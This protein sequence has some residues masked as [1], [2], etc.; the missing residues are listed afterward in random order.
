[1]VDTKYPNIRL[2]DICS[3]PPRNGI[4]KKTE[5]L[6]SG[7]RLIKMNE[8]FSKRYIKNDDFAEFINLTSSEKEKLLINNNDLL[9]SRTSV[10]ADGVGMCS[11]VIIGNYEFTWD[12]NIIRI[13]LNNNTVPRYYFYFFNSPL[14]RNM[15]TS[16]ASGATVT[17]ITGKNLLELNVPSPK[18][19]VQQKIASILSAYDDLIE[20]NSRRIKILEEIAQSIYRE[21][22][23]TTKES[24]KTVKISDFGQIVTGKTPSKKIE[25]NFNQKYIR[26]IKTPDMHGNLFCL[27][28]TEWLS[29]IGANSQKNKTIPVNSICVSCIGTGGVISI[30]ACDAQT[31][32]QI[33][34]IIPSKEYYL[35]YLYFSLKDLKQVMLNIGSKGATMMN[36][37]KA[38]FGNIDIKKPND[39]LIENFHKLVNPIFELVKNLQIKNI[40]LSQTKNLLLPK[41]ISGDL[42]IEDLDIKIRPEI[43]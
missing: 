42:D 29:E 34:T 9:F 14:G 11:L 18:L 20:N 26:F 12:S 13:R 23:V 27:E 28:T 43:L 1:M 36:L 3:M 15:V 10:V 21:R 32:Q 35:E 2:G 6:S 7:V 19:N 4:Y 17:T 24:Y 33:N 40:N 8:L 5:N 37:N 22:F 30:T 25:E 41:L 39:I 31:N 16:L 38:E